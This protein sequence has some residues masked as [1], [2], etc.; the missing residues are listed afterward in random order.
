MVRVTGVAGDLRGRSHCHAICDDLDQAS[1]DRVF[2]DEPIPAL[3]TVRAGA[4]AGLEVDLV[5]V[6]RLAVNLIEAVCDPLGDHVLG[7]SSL[8]AAALDTRASRTTD[9]AFRTAMCLRHGF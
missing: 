5:G 8:E 9:T 2:V 6:A 7:D 4:C 1:P 3:L